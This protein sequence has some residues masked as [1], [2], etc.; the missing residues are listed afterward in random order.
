M[1]L[2]RKRLQI[3]FLSVLFIFL[4]KV[5]KDYSQSTS[6]VSSRAYVE[7][8]IPGPVILDMKMKPDCP[9]SYLAFRADYGRT[10]NAVV[11]LDRSLMT[12]NYLNRTLVVPKNPPYMEWF[13]FIATKHT[14]C[15]I[16]E[17]YLE[18]NRTDT[19]KALM[20]IHFDFWLDGYNWLGKPTRVARI[21]APHEREDFKTDE[22][23]PRLREKVDPC[24]RCMSFFSWWSIGEH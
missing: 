15:I 4:Y 12:A 5:T 17:E 1:S 6:W 2:Q 16:S 10:N 23:L 20:W 14:H 13:D 11:Q 18:L 22:L 19:I 8:E 21:D 7:K 24:K 3:L 9:R